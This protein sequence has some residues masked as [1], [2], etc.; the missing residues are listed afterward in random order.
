MPSDD[1]ICQ[2]RIEAEQ[3]AFAQVHKSPKLEER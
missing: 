2:V 3:S 1:Q